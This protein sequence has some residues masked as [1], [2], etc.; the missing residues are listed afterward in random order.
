MAPRKKPIKKGRPATTTGDMPKVESFAVEAEAGGPSSELPSE[1][2]PK[3]DTALEIDDEEVNAFV[4]EP[5]AEGDV[6]EATV[7]GNQG[8]LA[9]MEGLL[10]QELTFE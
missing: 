9:C 3:D 2:A 5:D 8:T 10:G 1:D 4:D 7:P 6:V